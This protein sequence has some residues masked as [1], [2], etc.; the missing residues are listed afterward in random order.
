MRRTLVAGLTALATL[1]AGCSGGVTNGQGHTAAASGGGVVL[2]DPDPAAL[3][4]GAPPRAGEGVTYQADV[5]IVPAGGT[6]VRGVTDGGFTWSLDPAAAGVG[7]L[8]KGAVMLV[9]GRGVGRVVAVDRGGPDT[10]VTIAPVSITDVVR[11][12]TFRTTTPVSLDQPLTYQAPD[13]FWSAGG[14]T[15]AAGLP[16]DTGNLTRTTVIAPSLPV[17]TRGGSGTV[18]VGGFAIT[19]TCC[20]DGAG[21]GYTYDDGKVRLVGSFR[22]K[23]SKPTAT[24]DLRISGAKVTYANLSLGGAAGIRAEIEA[25]SQAFSPIDKLIPIPLDFDVPIANILGVPL[26]A[27]IHQTLGVHT[28][29]SSK[30]ANIK[31][32]GEWDFSGGLS[33]TY[34]G[35]GFHAEAPSSVTK[36]VAVLD[37]IS[38]IATGV[39][40]IA[41]D[42]N[43]RVTVGIGAFGFTAGVYFSFAAHLYLVRNSAL[44]APV[45]V[46]NIAQLIL[47]T[48]YGIGYSIPR[49]VADLINF[50]LA[51][52]K[53]PPVEAHGGIGK[54]LDVSFDKVAYQPDSTYCRKQK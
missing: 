1:V 41:I 19:G 26:H 38:G 3:R 29:F 16:K 39:V 27:N 31:A 10:V 28:F 18:R 20:R 34:D 46:C 54:D 32:T 52:F 36:K 44:G 14:T 25:G 45:A 47:Y 42:Y 48:G 50:F 33:F 35:S 24:F 9:A 15:E 8:A 17:P 22:L 51:K 53:A 5:V 2:S 37:T 40:G 43:T 21:V 12:G 4:Y 30:D 6:A 7:K 49:P 13:A 11:D 23:M